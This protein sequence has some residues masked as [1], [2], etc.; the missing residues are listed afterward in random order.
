MFKHYAILILLL[1]KWTRWHGLKAGKDDLIIIRKKFLL[2]NLRLWNGYWVEICYLALNH[3]L[4][5]YILD[6][7]EGD[8]ML[9]KITTVPH[10]PAM[11][12][13]RKVDSSMVRFNWRAVSSLCRVRKFRLV[14]GS[15]VRQVWWVNFFLN[16]NIY[17]KNF[18]FIFI[19]IF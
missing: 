10:E 19:F 9:I 17:K 1:W 2:V 3:D 14:Y 11:P 4:N 15:R 5:Y 6:I 7:Y 18:R 13:R 8:A 12:V 16:M